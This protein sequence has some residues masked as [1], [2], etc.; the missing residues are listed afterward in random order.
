MKNGEGGWDEI[1]SGSEGG[2]S[3]L[4]KISAAYPDRPPTNDDSA[5]VLNT[6]AIVSL[7]VVITVVLGIIVMV[8]LFTGRFAYKR[9]KSKAVIHQ[10]YTNINEEHVS[11]N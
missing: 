5:G 9:C 3:L 8:V 4:N 10:F 6:G 7:T 11:P 2:K 1:D